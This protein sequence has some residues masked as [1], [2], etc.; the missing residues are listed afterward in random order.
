MPSVKDTIGSA[1]W[2]VE[3]FHKLR[4][5]IPAERTVV[6]EPFMARVGCRLRILGVEWASTNEFAWVMMQCTV[7]GV[8][9]L[10]R[11]GSQS[12]ISRSAEGARLSNSFFEMHEEQVR[13]NRLLRSTPPAEVVALAAR[14]I[15]QVRYG[16]TE[17]EE[18]VEDLISRIRTQR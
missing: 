9:K 16:R 4:E 14:L 15:D 13:V 7:I 6:T 12:W 1:K 10:E 17:K 18:S 5:A 3:N 11:E 8:F 2:V